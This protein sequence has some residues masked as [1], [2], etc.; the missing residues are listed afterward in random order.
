MRLLSASGA[1]LNNDVMDQYGQVEPD[2]PDEAEDA[3]VPLK[4]CSVSDVQRHSLVIGVH[5]NAGEK[6]TF[7]DAENWAGAY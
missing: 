7:S 5:C 4:A 6:G 3:Q 2:S 1:Q